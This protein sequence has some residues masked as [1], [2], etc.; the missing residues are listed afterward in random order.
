MNYTHLEFVK[1][2]VNNEDVIFLLF[3]FIHLYLFEMM[4]KII[5]IIIEKEFGIK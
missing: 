4:S 2:K 5:F 3:N 1:T